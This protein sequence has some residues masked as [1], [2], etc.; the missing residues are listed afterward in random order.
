MSCEK[1]IP[2][3]FAI[4]KKNYE[5]IKWF[6]ESDSKEIDDPANSQKKKDALA[7]ISKKQAEEKKIAI[8]KVNEEEG[9]KRQKI[10]EEYADEMECLKQ[11]QEENELQ[12]KIKAL[13]G[14]EPEDELL[15]LIY[16][17]NKARKFYEKMMLDIL[18]VKNAEIQGERVALLISDISDKV[19]DALTL[20]R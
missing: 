1:Y 17:E 20:R 13:L 12:V 10:V 16:K 7:A 2:G 6:S 4:R 14:V 18:D 15:D 8:Q 9:G 5:L 3:A 19:K 11:A